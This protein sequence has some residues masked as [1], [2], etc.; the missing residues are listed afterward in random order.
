MDE[1]VFWYF[2]GNRV[3]NLIIDGQPSLVS[4]HSYFRAP[5]GQTFPAHA[6]HLFKRKNPPAEIAAKFGVA[7]KIAEQARQE[8]EKQTVEV[9]KAK[10][11][12]PRDEK[13]K[14]PL[15]MEKAILEMSSEVPSG[16]KPKSGSESRRERKDRERKEREP[17]D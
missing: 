11:E 13:A 1:K 8:I 6:K 2:V 4:P 3:E 5:A 10:E 7:P 12:A 16:E 17:Q 14:E 9:L 15:P